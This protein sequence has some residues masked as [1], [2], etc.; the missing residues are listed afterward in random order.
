MTILTSETLLRLHG[1]DA[2]KFLQGQTTAD[3]AEPTA[4]STRRGAFCDPKG[5]VLADFLAASIAED[6]IVLRVRASIAEALV[7]HLKRYLMFSKAT[8]TR[9]DWQVGAL[10]EDSEGDTLIDS[11]SFWTIP[12]GR[13]LTEVWTTGDSVAGTLDNNAAQLAEIALGEA[14]IEA[15]TQGQ[16]LPQDLNYDLNGAVSFTKGCYTGQEIVARLH[17]RGTPKRRLYPAWTEGSTAP[18]PGTALVLSGSGR[19]QGSIVNSALAPGGVALLIEATED[20][21]AQGLETADGALA[22]S[23]TAPGN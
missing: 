11:G 21:L 18:T 4:G 5:R 9:T 16:Y 6:D 1:I 12:R 14:R 7:E 3:F 13:G 10:A 17:Y 22:L 19:T 15:S 23:A 20:A 8:L 2:A